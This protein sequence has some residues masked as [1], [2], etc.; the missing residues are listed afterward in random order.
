MNFNL[1]KTKPSKINK[2]LHKMAK[3]ELMTSFT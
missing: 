1:N 3:I 2:I